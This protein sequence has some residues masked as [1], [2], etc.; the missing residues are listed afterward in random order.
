MAELNEIR[1]LA[2][3]FNSCLKSEKL[4]NVGIR[5][6]LRPLEPQ[7]PGGLKPYSLEES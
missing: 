4:P 6:E 7:S 2:C 3:L 5:G 1:V